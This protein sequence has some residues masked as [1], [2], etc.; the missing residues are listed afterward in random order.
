MKNESGV[1]PVGRRV[2]VKPDVIKSKVGE[3]YLPEQELERH[4]QA[5]STRI[6]IAVGD[7]AFIHG[8]E[9]VHRLVDGE[10][11]LVERRVDRRKTMYAQPG[12]RIVFA[13]FGG[14]QIPGKD[15]I[16]YRLMNDE[17]ITALADDEIKFGSF[18]QAR[19][20]VV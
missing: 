9:E 20:S 12:D 19:E 13:V 7:D 18:D 3:I 14:K 4:Q 11:K 16:E 6:L 10:M 8:V 1:T 2:L 15:G 5:V 17:D